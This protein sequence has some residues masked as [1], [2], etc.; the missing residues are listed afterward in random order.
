VYLPKEKLAIQAD[1][2]TP[3]AANA[4][5]PTPPNP[6]TVNLSENIARLKL[7]VAQHMPLHGRIVPAAE[8]NKAIGK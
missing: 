1:A 8:L 4:K 2:F 6:F 5:Y 7:D 3:V